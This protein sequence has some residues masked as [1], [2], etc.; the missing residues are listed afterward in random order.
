MPSIQ[1][2]LDQLVVHV[3]TSLEATGLTGAVK[4]WR[5]NPVDNAL[6]IHISSEGTQPERGLNPT[7]G[8]APHCDFV[9]ALYV[10]NRQRSE[11]ELATAEAQLNAVEEQIIA[12]V[13][14]WR[15]VWIKAHIWKKSARPPSPHELRH[16]RLGVMY[17]RTIL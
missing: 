17:V 10:P 1:E 12:D 3:T 15:D 5:G 8:Q 4:G 9:L 11:A 14:H 13:R 6:E 16:W 7:S 2:C